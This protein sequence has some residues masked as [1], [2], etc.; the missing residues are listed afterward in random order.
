[1]GRDSSR[2]LKGGKGPAPHPGLLHSTQPI[3]ARGLHGPRTA[4]SVQAGGSPHLTPHPTSSWDAEEPPGQLP[5]DPLPARLPIPAES[6]FGSVHALSGGTGKG[7]HIPT[8]SPLHSPS[9]SA[10]PGK[11]HITFFF[12]FITHT[13]PK[14]APLAALAS[15]L[16]APPKP[17]AMPLAPQPGETNGS[18]GN[19]WAHGRKAGLR[20]PGPAQRPE[21]PALK[22]LKLRLPS[23]E[24]PGPHGPKPPYDSEASPGP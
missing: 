1:M 8:F 3:A 22:S 16:R 11:D 24:A 10:E 19:R 13:A 17:L 18:H 4:L 5:R 6:L 15:P 14:P 7:Q 21:P 9:P 20:S 2:G 12:T 23:S